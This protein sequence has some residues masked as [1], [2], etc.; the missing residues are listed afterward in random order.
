MD[1]TVLERAARKALEADPTSSNDPAT[2]TLSSSKRMA[3]LWAGYGQIHRHTF[4]VTS[5]TSSKDL[6]L[7]SKRVE[8]P[9]S[10]SNGQKPSLSH[11]RKLKSYENEMEFYR[12]LIQGDAEL[13]FPSS[14]LLPP[15]PRPY[16]LWQPSEGRFE[17]VLEDLEVPF[18]DE[19]VDPLPRTETTAVLR[20]LAK[21]HG[22]FWESPHLP[23]PL[24][25]VETS[26]STIN[27]KL[28]KVKAED[29]TE[30]VGSKALEN[31]ESWPLHPVGTY[32]HLSTRLDEH[33]RISTT[34]SLNHR[35]KLAAPAIHGLLA[36]GHCHPRK[37]PTRR[38]RTLVH[39]DMK[40][41]NLLFRL[42]QQT[43]AAVDFQYTGTGLGV[44]D[45]AYF[46][47][48]SVDSTLLQNHETML[49]DYHSMLPE[50]VRTSLSLDALNHQFALAVVDFARFLMG[51]GIWGHWQWTRRF[52]DVWMGKV[53]D[54]KVLDEERYR[55]RVEAVWGWCVR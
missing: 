31:T 52:V 6:C 50:R 27:S 9:K 39:G 51:W 11:A 14:Q 30:N 16:H 4:R 54:G 42:D 36:Y 23:L 38:Y 45:L 2:I 20:W 12:L 10:E 18:P 55:E 35:L 49:S 43:C 41:E 32:W 3:S 1:N 48:T 13:H 15:L 47:I 5:P 34:P 19:P 29:K 28:K 46:F 26:S 17:F 44:Q 22:A 37:P 21:F 7:V 24:F 33:A 8:A 40:L 53:D 25:P